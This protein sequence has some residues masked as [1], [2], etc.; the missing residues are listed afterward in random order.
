MKKEMLDYHKVHIPLVVDS[1][2]Q[3]EVELP[4]VGVITFQA[5]VINISDTDEMKFVHL[6]SP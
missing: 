3:Q 2:A 5:G 4:T 1:S 6:E